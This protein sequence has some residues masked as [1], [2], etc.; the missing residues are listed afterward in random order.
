[1][2][3]GFL[4]LMGLAL[5]GLMLLAFRKQPIVDRILAPVPFILYS[6]ALPAWLWRSR[7]EF[8]KIDDIGLSIERWPRDVEIR[9]HEIVALRAYSLSMSGIRTVYHQVHSPRATIKFTDKLIDSEHLPKVIAD[10]TGLGW[11]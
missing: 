1:L 8:L 6:V 2:V 9:W 3:F 5:A 11:Q 7:R 10:A 4:S